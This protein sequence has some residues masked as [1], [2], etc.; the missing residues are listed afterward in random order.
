MAA[1]R[2]A[3]R[4]LAPQTQN[5]SSLAPRALRRQTPKVGAGC[6]KAARTDLCGGT[7][8]TRFPT[9]I[10]NMSPEV[11]VA[12][13]P[14][15]SGRATSAPPPARQHRLVMPIV[16]DGQD[17]VKPGPT[18]HRPRRQGLDGASPAAAPATKRSM[19]PCRPALNTPSAVG[20]FSIGEKQILWIT[21]SN[22]IGLTNTYRPL[23]AFK[24]FSAPVVNFYRRETPHSEDR[25]LAS[26]SAAA[27]AASNVSAVPLAIRSSR[28]LPTFAPIARIRPR[29]HRRGPLYCETVDAL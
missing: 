22:V 3:R 26:K 20:D 2:E 10:T 1:D 13:R 18:G 28:L 19:D 9:A 29:L 17:A 5:P 15:A 21:D 24:I 12:S 7:G 16:R 14:D 23:D 11:L 6:G 4:R 25:A 27:F 8:A